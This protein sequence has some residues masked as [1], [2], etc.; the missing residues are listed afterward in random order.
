MDEKRISSAAGQG[1]EYLDGP[2]AVE[3]REMERTEDTAQ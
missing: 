3:V 2:A 1:S